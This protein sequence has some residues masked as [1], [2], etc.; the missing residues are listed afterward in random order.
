[1]TFWDADTGEVR[2]SI[3]GHFG[4]LAFSPD[5]ERLATAVRNGFKL[6]DARTG[7]EVYS[8]KT[9]AAVT[10]FAFRAD[11]DYLAAA[12]SS[13]SI[14]VL[15]TDSVLHQAHLEGA[16]PNNAVFSPDGRLVAASGP[17]SSVLLFDASTG[18]QLHQL[19]DHK[20]RVTKVVFSEDSKRLLASCYDELS[21]WNVESRERALRL[22]DLSRWVHMA[23]LSPDGGRLAALV[24]GRGKEDGPL[25]GVVEVRTWDVAT[26][27]SLKPRALNASVLYGAGPRFLVFLDGDRTI[28]LMP[29]DNSLCAW[30][31]ETLEKVNPPANLLARVEHQARL[32]ARTADGRHL[33]RGR[34]HTLLKWPPD[35]AELE[36]RQALAH[37]DQGWHVEK[38]ASAEREGRW[39][40]AAFHL[41][42]LLHAG[43]DVAL[44]CR[45]ARAYLALSRWREA[46]ADCDEAIRAEPRSIDAWFTRALLAYR[47][48]DLKEA[49]AHLARAAAAAPDDPAMDAWQ[50]L[51]YLAERQGEQA[52]TAERR[53]LER[54]AILGPVD[55][56]WKSKLP[57]TSSAWSVLEDELTRC[58]AK[59]PKE[60]A[61]LRLRG[62]VRTARGQL[63]TD[64]YVVGQQDAYLDFREAAKLRPKD[65][66]TCKVLACE[67][68]KR[69]VHYT[70]AGGFVWRDKVK[71]ALEACDTV[72]AENASAWEFWYLRGLFC[73]VHGQQTAA[74]EA[75]NRALN[76]RPNFAPALRERGELYA[77][78]EKWAEAVRDLSRAA[79]LTGPNDPTVW[80]K[81]ALAHLGRGDTLAYKRTC[82]RMLGMYGQTAPLTWVGGAFGA[83][84]MNPCA[85]PLALLA[86]DQAVGTSWEGSTL[87]AVRCTTLPDTLTDWQRLLPLTEHSGREVRARVLCRT[88]YHDEA[89]ELL[90]S[91]RAERDIP[92]R[93]SPLLVLYQALAEQGRG[94]TA[95]AKQLKEKTDWLDKPMPGNPRQKNLHRYLWTERVQI[96]QLSSE[97]KA[98]LR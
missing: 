91:L 29:P 68:W 65:V 88:G 22:K 42:R 77:E 23:V 7:Q 30:S 46:R 89:I 48:N 52:A 37:P 13:G 74:L 3:Q 9:S 66:L 71:E 83:G 34:K 62:A 90:E 35:R 61:L 96:D 57:S 21:V 18:K 69:I 10:R 39:F 44:R 70:P 94:R 28:A 86:A 79:E 38:A 41:G 67:I 63:Q 82:T 53:M 47:Q 60:V 54:L 6:W 80:D 8:Y 92:G 75:F 56:N 33:F 4:T 98:L 16:S 1:V 17:D 5:G 45:R 31:V 19:K 84:P 25:T 93:A 49:Q 24:Q 11:G 87:T 26:G 27:K 36:R 40:A 43:P 85:V 58:L 20:G 59:N 81:L 64:P 51:I 78:M 15:A 32:R 14:Q 73:T 97:L 12:T 50:A 55:R 95:Q 2:F 76:L 72:L